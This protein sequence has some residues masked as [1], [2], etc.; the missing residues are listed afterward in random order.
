MR[1]GIV[2]IEFCGKIFTNS[3]SNWHFLLTND[4]SFLYSWK[5]VLQ[6][7]VTLDEITRCQLYWNST[8]KIFD[9]RERNILKNSWISS[10]RQSQKLQRRPLVPWHVMTFIL[11]MLL[12]AHSALGPRQIGLFLKDTSCPG[13]APATSPPHHRSRSPWCW[14]G[15][16]RAWCW[17][18]RCR[19]PW[20]FHVCWCRSGHRDGPGSTG[21]TSPCSG[22]SSADSGSRRSWRWR[23]PGGR[24]GSAG[25]AAGP[26]TLRANVM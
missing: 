8:G 10:W 3:I 21:R 6:S 9:N 23:G 16:G 11:T 1:R 24:G 12:M 4:G 13:A 5:R 7:F 20:S 2:V 25:R 17:W 26:G 22:H 14:P 18:C 15:L 19:P